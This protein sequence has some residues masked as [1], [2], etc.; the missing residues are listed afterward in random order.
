[1]ALVIF[2]VIVAE[3]G[4]FAPVQ[5]NPRLQQLSSGARGEAV[6]QLQTLLSSLGYSPGPIDGVFGRQT[7]LAL[8]RY[9]RDRGLV[10]D[11]V[12][13]RQT[14][15]ALERDWQAQRQPAAVPVHR[16]RMHVVRP[17]ETLQT[18][19]VR[20]G[21]TWLDLSRFNHLADPNRVLVGQALF[22]P[23][24]G[25]QPLQ[26]PPTSPARPPS[27]G[28]PRGPAAGAVALTFNGGPH[29]GHTPAILEALARGQ[30]RATF[31]VRGK[32]A[33]ANPGLVKLMAEQGHEVGNHG[34]AA[35]SLSG[36]SLQ[37]I[38]AEI[39]RTSLKVRDLTGRP[40]RL[41]RPPGGALDRNVRLAAA[42]QDHAIVMWTNIGALTGSGIPRLQLLQR[43]TDHARDGAVIMLRVDDADTVEV[44]PELIASLQQRGFAFVTLGRALEAARAGG[45]K[46]S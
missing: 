32:L 29:P 45:R 10:V 8:R 42:R 23:D 14:L 27:P 38:E 41:F 39:S 12:L 5:A 40:T 31:F 26:A 22:I 17:G 46:G 28:T 2:C 30:V 20:Y 16:G 4:G 9:Q 19:A 44:L 34:Y 25:S 7:E 18:I 37:V 15:A 35:Q 3:V 33:E 21:L 6:R 1:M 13:G 36:Q 43:L 11:G 24:P